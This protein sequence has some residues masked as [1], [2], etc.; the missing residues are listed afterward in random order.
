MSYTIMSDE[1]YEE[2]MEH[3]SCIGAELGKVADSVGYISFDDFTALKLSAL[4]LS[5]ALELAKLDEVHEEDF[6]VINI[7]QNI[8]DKILVALENKGIEPE[9]VHVGVGEVEIKVYA[10]DY[11][12]ALDVI[13]E[14]TCGGF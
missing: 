7:P 6:R 13:D 4:K 10:E 9:D 5:T 1:V 2:V 8:K 11:V 3:W 14:V 12:V